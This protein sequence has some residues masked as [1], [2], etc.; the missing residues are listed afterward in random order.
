MRIELICDDEC[1]NVGD[2]RINL[3]RALAAAGWPP[4]WTEWN[5]SDP[6]APD[7]IRR[8]GSPTILVDGVEIADAD[9]LN[10]GRCCRIYRYADQRLGGV[11]PID[12]IASAVRRRTRRGVARW[13]Q[14]LVPLPSIGIAL[15][16]KLACPACWPAYAGLLSSVGLGF[17]V[18]S[19]KLFMLTLASLA[20]ALG[21]IAFQGFVRRRSGALVLGTIAATSTVLGKFVFSSDVVLYASVVALIGASAWSAWPIRTKAPASGIQCSKSVRS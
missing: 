1:P 7:E 15:L 21:A 11:P 17:L 16:P 12:L 20:L 2:T 4:Q 10:S 5:R 6:N 19:S 18:P 3:M 9:D 8:F 14:K 13:M